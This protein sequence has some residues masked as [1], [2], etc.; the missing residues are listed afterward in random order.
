MYASRTTKLFYKNT[1]S[2]NLWKVRSKM[3]TYSVSEPKLRIVLNEDVSIPKSLGDMDFRKLL[4]E[5][6]EDGLSLLG[7]CSKQTLYN[8]LESNFKI[9][10]QDIPDKIEQFSDAI[11][12]I[13][14]QSAKLLQIEIIKNLYKKVKSD[15]E[16]PDKKSELVFIEYVKALSASVRI[17]EKI[18]Y[19]LYKLA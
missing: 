17:P 14:G 13:F 10:K 4:L 1:I 18:P 7:D 19:S 3:R 2:L 16:Y 5:A 12:K 15:F 9:G 8:H 11:E 6:V